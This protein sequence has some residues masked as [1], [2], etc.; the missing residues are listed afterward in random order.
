MTICI[1]KLTNGE[2]LISD[3]DVVQSDDIVIVLLK[4][5]CSINLMPTENGGIGVQ[6]IPWMIYAKDH[7]VPMP[8]DMIMT[9]VEATTDLYNKY[10]LLFGTGIQVP[11]NKIV[12]S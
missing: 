12:L 3:T 7:I 2:D 9:Q 11:D 5:P 10:N 8:A 4:K 6:L 1:T